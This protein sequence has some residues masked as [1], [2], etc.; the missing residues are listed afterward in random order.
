RRLTMDLL[1]AEAGT[2]GGSDVRLWWAGGGPRSLEGAAWRRVGWL[3]G[4]QPVAQ[5]RV[6]MDERRRLAEQTGW[7]PPVA[8]WVLTDYDASTGRCGDRLS[9]DLVLQ[10]ARG[11]TIDTGAGAWRGSVALGEI[12]DVLADLRDVRDC[13]VEHMVFD[14][15]FSKVETWV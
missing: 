13:G 8:V 12:D 11:G 4:R 2:A 5:L 15:R 7:A 9:A 1:Q 3:A 10:H 6:R 14:F